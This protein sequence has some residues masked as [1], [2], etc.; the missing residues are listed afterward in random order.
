MILN[1]L[2]SYYKKKHDERLTTKFGKGFSTTNLKQM[3]DFYQTYKI[4]QTESD[5]FSLCWPHYLFLVLSD[6]LKFTKKSNIHLLARKGNPQIKNGR[7]S[8]AT[9]DNISSL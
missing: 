6:A 8:R 1:I 9:P 4:S 5:Q 7:G 3:R 2:L